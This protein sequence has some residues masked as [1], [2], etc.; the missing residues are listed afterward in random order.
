[1]LPGFALGFL[2][3]CWMHN[4]STTGTR[5]GKWRGVN[6]AFVS[7]WDFTCDPGTGR[8]L[9]A[10]GGGGRPGVLPGLPFPQGGGGAAK[11]CRPVSWLPK[12][13]QPTA[14]TLTLWWLKFGP[15]EGVG[16]EGGWRCPAPLAPNSDPGFLCYAT[17]GQT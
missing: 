2:D 4:H 9:A 13:G 12:G 5:G 14:C 3:A 16:G 1:M 17:L 11:A 7:G 10:G 6:L 8:G 15:T